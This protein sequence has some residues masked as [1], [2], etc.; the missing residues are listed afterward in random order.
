MATTFTC[1]GD[2]DWDTANGGLGI[3]K[4]H[5]ERPQ[6]ANLSHSRDLELGPRAS[7]TGTL[8]GPAYNPKIYRFFV[9]ASS[10]FAMTWARLK[11]AGFWLRCRTSRRGALRGPGELTRSGAA[12]GAIEQALKIPISAEP[13]AP[14]VLVGRLALTRCP[15][16]RKAIA[17]GHWGPELSRYPGT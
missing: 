13:S 17:P 10:I 14:R 3:S 15:T 9:L 7:R 11:V 4:S 12:S 5:G 8:A 1:Y 16:F 6:L 2:S